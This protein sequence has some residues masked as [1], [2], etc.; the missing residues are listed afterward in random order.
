MKKRTYVRI[1]SFTLLGLGILFASAV[2]NTRNMDSYKEQLEVSYQQSL[3][4]LSECMSAVNTDLNKSLYSNSP[5]EQQQLSRELFAKCSVAKNAVSRL[6]VSQMELGSTYKFLSQ[7]SDYAQYIEKKLESGKK[8][9]EQEHKNLK[10]LL[11]YSERFS[12]SVS[13]MS[14]LV[15]GGLK[16]TDGAVKSSDKISVTPLSNSFSESAKSFESF[17]SLLYDGPFSDRILN[18]KSKLI[19]DSEIK[20]REE[21]RAIAAKALDISE[22][23]VIFD[24]DERSLLP[25]YTFKCGRYTVS[26]TKQ[27]GYIK[28]ILYSGIINSTQISADNAVNLAEKYL[29]SVGYK[30][31]KETYYSINE[32][33]CTVNFAY[34]K[35][36]VYYYSDH[37][38]VGIS[39]LDGKTLSLDASTYLTNHTRRPAF[40][41]KISAEKA[42]KKL[43]P[44]LRV[45]GVK[46]CVIPKENGTEAQCWEYL[47][48]SSDTGED[49]LVYLNSKTGEE[50]DIMLL[51]YTDGGTVTE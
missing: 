23:R 37:I 8:I 15:S 14:R 50:E 44:Y 24:S 11:D 43:S 31:M 26:V 4:E 36:G 25:C 41:S 32:N 49:A 20:T 33:V 51:L 47:C 7:A 40:K 6:P 27:G 16:I 48:T 38:K 10:V 2:I 21:C 3:S 19:S 46:K 39:M 42:Q 29:D 18:K 45:K 35:N 1:A 9:T 12:R 22:N 5:S 13:E 17:P 30:N 34:T 28:S